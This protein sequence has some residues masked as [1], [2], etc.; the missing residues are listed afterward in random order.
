MLA[1]KR[2]LEIE[3][4]NLQ[5]RLTMVQVAETSSGLNLSDNQLCQTQRLL[6]DIS[7]RIEV[8]ERIV[9]S[10]GSLGGEIPIDEATPADI[11]DQISRY[12]DNDDTQAENL[13]VK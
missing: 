6:D 12:F 7:S 2:R 4:E 3:V 9:D 8:A 5:A 11:V 1:A 10:E 13:A